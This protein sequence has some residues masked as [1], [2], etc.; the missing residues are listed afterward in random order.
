MSPLKSQM[1]FIDVFKRAIPIFLPI[2][3]LVIVLLDL[4]FHKASWSLVYLTEKAIAAV[5]TVTVYAGIT[6]WIWKPKT[7]SN[8][9]N[10][11]HA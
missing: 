5:V 3:L 7:A 11:K 1:R 8:P 9:T 10:D 4:A 2:Y 6:W